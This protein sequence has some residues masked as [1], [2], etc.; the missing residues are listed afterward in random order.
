MPTLPDHTRG[1][2]TELKLKNEL[3]E[4][5]VSYEASVST[6]KRYLAALK[7]SNERIRDLEA[8]LDQ[9][10]TLWD[11]LKSCFRRCFFKTHAT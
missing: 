5:M 2:D 3:E 8:Q 6:Q 4:I 9:E 1:M 11:Y 7:E 10:I